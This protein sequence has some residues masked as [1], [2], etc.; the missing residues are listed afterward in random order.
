MTYEL[1]TKINDAD[2]KKFLDTIEDDQKKEDSLRVL[3]IFE[4]ISGYKAKMWWSNI[5]WFGTYTYKYASGQTWDW[6]RTWFAPRA[7]GLSL[8]IMPWYE[9]WNMKELMS[10]LWKHKAW[11]SC[12][13]IKKLSDIDLKV[14]E[15]I[16]KAWLDDMKEKY[17]E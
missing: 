10:K 5:V 4:R 14:L 9:F 7:W 17:P 12:I 3:E 1:K 11:R 2:V 16:I 6:M 13:N 15:K 8:Y